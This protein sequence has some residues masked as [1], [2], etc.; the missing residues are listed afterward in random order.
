MLGCDDEKGKGREEGGVKISGFGWGLGL[1]CIGYTRTDGRQTKAY[2]VEGAS[3]QR[4]KTRRALDGNN[5]FFFVF[6]FL[7]CNH[8]EKCLWK[9]EP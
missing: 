1:G 5:F 9:E 7:V 8:L 4:P 2:I 6:F 3:A